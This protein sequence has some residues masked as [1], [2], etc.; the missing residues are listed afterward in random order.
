[1]QTPTIITFFC[2]AVLEQLQRIHILAVRFQKWRSRT[3]TISLQFDGYQHSRNLRRQSTNKNKTPTYSRERAIV[4]T[5]A[6]MFD[7]ENTGQDLAEIRWPKCLLSNYKRMQKEMF[8]T[9][10]VM[11]Y[12]CNNSEYLTFKLMVRDAH[13][14]HKSTK[15]TLLC[16]S[17]C[18][19]WYFATDGYMPTDWRRH[20]IT[21][22][23][24]SML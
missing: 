13:N 24:R 12:N 16:Q 7:L 11:E 22:L 1:M 19:Q 3:S 5:V 6:F 15:K 9:S 21:T 2:S 18:F 14:L 4:K 20:C 10:A 23:H 8:Q 17:V